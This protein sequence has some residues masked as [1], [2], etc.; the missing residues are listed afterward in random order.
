MGIQYVDMTRLGDSA[1]IIRLGNRID[2]ET[3]TKVRALSRYLENH[4]FEGMVE[5][6]PA[7]ASV[8]VVYDPVRIFRTTGGSNSLEE[9]R[10]P[11]E[12]V[13]SR[14]KNL[15]DHLQEDN[16]PDHR[17]VEI[18]VCYGEELGPDLKHVAGMTGWSAEEVIRIHAGTEY[19]VYMLGFAPGFPYLGGMDKRIAAPRKPTPR[20]SIPPGTVG[21]AGEQTGIYPIETPGGWQ[22]I[23]R[24]PL[25]LFLPDKEPPTLLEAGDRIRFYPIT[26]KEYDRWEGRG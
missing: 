16:V 19:L 7:Y 18:P 10:Y 24:T 11:Y 15:L 13:E 1:I 8:T 22:L 4:S 3:H 23:G 14:L 5:V 26:R 12:E 2:E 25:P 21:I 17:V 20:L 9:I 6:I